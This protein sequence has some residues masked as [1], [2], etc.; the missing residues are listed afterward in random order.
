MRRSSLVTVVC[1][2][3]ICAAV[4]T[5]WSQT[6]SAKYQ[7]GTIMSVATHHSAEQHDS[8][9]TQYDVTVKVA[10]TNYVVL[11]SPLNGST[12]VKY[13]AGDEVLVLVG[14]NTLTVNNPGL[15]RMAVPILSRETLPAQSADWSK[16]PGNYFRTKLQHLS[17]NLALTAD[18]QVKI[19]PILEQEGDQIGELFLNPALSSADE[20]NGYER[21]SHE[22][23]ETLKP[24]LSKDQL[25]KLRD[26]RKEQKQDVKRIIGE[27]KNS[28]TK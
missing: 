12:S 16:A 2:T 13:V 24:L 5:A 17:E 25:Q 26:L 21:I 15:G 8:D 9:V 6:S 11:F 14:S 23:D 1:V 19:K 22:S 18:Q 4:L 10:N 7:P 3:L 20:L 28:K 27:Q